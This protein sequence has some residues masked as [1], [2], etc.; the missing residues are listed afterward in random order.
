MNPETTKKN[1]NLLA[2]IPRFW[3]ATVSQENFD[4][5]YRWGQKISQYPSEIQHLF[6]YLV[7]EMNDDLTWEDYDTFRKKVIE[8]LEE[9]YGVQVIPYII[10]Y[11]F[12]VL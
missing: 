3:L 7:P 8:C 10:H 1:K 2:I 12:Y 11:Y 9:E 5:R 4:L 6:Q